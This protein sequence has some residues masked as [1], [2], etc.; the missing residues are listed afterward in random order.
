MFSA[1]KSGGVVGLVVLA[2]AV[3]VHGQLLAQCTSDCLNSMQFCLTDDTGKCIQDNDKT[4]T[5][6]F[7][8]ELTTVGSCWHCGAANG[9]D[10]VSGYCINGNAKLVCKKTGLPTNLWV[11]MGLKRK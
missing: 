2:F 3:L 8:Y 4:K 6:C 10:G 9:G 5:K 1:F 11:L 7:S